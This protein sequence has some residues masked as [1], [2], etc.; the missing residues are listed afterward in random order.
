MALTTTGDIGE[1]ALFGELPGTRAL[2]P[3]P[4]SLTVL[5]AGSTSTSAQLRLKVAAKQPIDLDNELLRFERALVEEALNV[6]KDNL[7][8][9]AALLGI[10]FRQI[11][12]KVRQLGLR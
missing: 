1:A 5:G 3:L 4:G 11:R 6:T 10:S 8:D 12:Y 2:T 7:T 9:A